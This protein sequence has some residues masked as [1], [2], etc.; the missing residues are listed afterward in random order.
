MVALKMLAKPE[1]TGSY[2]E[3]FA[4]QRRVPR[5]SWSSMP[6]I[7]SPFQGSGDG[8]MANEWYPCHIGCLA[9]SDGMSVASTACPTPVPPW[10][11]QPVFEDDQLPM[12]LEFLNSC[13]PG[14]FSRWDVGGQPMKVE[15]VVD[16][17]HQD[18]AQD[19]FEVGS[20]KVQVT[21]K[22]G[23]SAHQHKEK[24]CF[25]QQAEFL[26]SSLWS[27]KIN[28]E[29]NLKDSKV[30]Q[31]ALGENTQSCWVTQP[32]VISRTQDKDVTR[33]EW[34]VD[35]RKI[36]G[37]DKVVVS[38]PF[39]MPSMFSAIFKMMITP[40]FVMNGKGGASFKKS[41]GKGSV[42]LKCESQ[43]GV[44]EGSMFF[45]I[46]IGCNDCNLSCVRQE[47]WNF[48]DVPLYTCQEERDFTKSLDV[49]R[50]GFSVILE[51]GPKRSER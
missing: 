44:N 25:T 9:E 14:N 38:P 41:K 33:I 15:N 3:G 17:C 23:M 36:K 13:P 1:E 21:H 12:R 5:G 30:T 24:P 28:L 4:N 51:V 7:K 19:S 45:Q 43:L 32:S 8:M 49:A 26:A 27:S 35:A 37:T 34:I 48:A 29:I 6:N 18:F 2:G 40:K 16:D 22:D 20:N 11:A 39:E 47:E 46:R 50:Q 10:H 42:Q 31:S